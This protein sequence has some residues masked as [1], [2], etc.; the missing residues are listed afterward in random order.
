MDTHNLPTKQ[1]ML[2]IM[3]RLQLARKGFDLLEK[4]RQVLQNE[5][6]L[7]KTS[8]KNIYS[9][10]STALKKAR[11]AIDTVSTEMGPYKFNQTLRTIKHTPV[12]NDL[13]CFRSI[14]GVELPMINDKYVFAKVEYEL[15]GTTISLDE[16]VLAWEKARH[17]IIAWATIENT[18]Y[19]LNLHIKKTQKRANALGNVVIPQYEAQIKSIKERLEERERDELAR[20]KLANKK[21]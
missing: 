11:R 19:R 16:A 15:P 13:Y 9:E 18:L 4:K 21:D 8:V 6:L 20:I 5:L 1:N 7:A 10:L 14:M 3:K 2:L 17:L 12:S